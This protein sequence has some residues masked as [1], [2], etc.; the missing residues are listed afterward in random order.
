MRNICNIENCKRVVRNKG[1]DK[2]G[3]RKYDVVCD[4]HHRQKG[5]SLKIENC[6]NEKCERCGWNKAYCDRH[7]IKPELGYIKSNVII[8]CPNCHRL[9]TIDNKTK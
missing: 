1:R 5:N 6:P 7:R 8:L 2:N 4:K 9:E 3:E